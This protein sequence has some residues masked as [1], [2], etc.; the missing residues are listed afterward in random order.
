MTAISVIKMKHNKI[1]Q[2]QNN[3]TIQQKNN[4]I[5]QSRNSSTIQQKN[6]KILHCRN[7]ST[8]QQKNNKILHCRNSSTIQ[9]KF[10]ETQAKSIPLTHIYMTLTHIHLF[11]IVLCLRYCIIFIYY[12]V[13]ALSVLQ[14]SFADGCQFC[15]VTYTFLCIH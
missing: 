13:N 5:L 14:H 9:Q 3:S 11:I 1:I 8:I 15:I 6:N 12:K 10:V 2:C 4:K 7:S